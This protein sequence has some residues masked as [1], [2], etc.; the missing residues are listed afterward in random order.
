MSITYSECV[1][2]ALVIQRTK[3]MRPNVLSSVACPALL[4]SSTLSHKRLDFRRNFTE[5]KMHV[6]SFFS[7]V[8]ETFLILRRIQQDVIINVHKSLFKVP[9]IHVKFR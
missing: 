5:H 6:L 2:I 3:R 7:I 4:H 8:S 1:F 9:V